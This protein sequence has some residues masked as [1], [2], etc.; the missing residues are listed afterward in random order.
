MM[1]Q[2]HYQQVNA[3][4]KQLM[5]N[6]CKSPRGLF[7]YPWLAT[8]AGKFY[9][10]RIFTWDAH[11][12]TL[13]F[14]MDGQPEMM[15]YFLLTM[16]QFQ[17]SNGFVPS[18]CSPDNGGNDAPGFHAQPYLAQNA[19]EYLNFSG[20]LETIGELFGKL[21]KYLDCWLTVYSAPFGLFRWEET[22]MSGFD[23]EITGTI[24]PT[25][26][27]LPPDL[28]SLLYLECRAMGYLARKLNLP[29]GE[30]EECACKIKDAVNDYLWDEEFGIYSSFNLCSGK[31]Q[32]SWGDGSLNSSVGKYAYI[33]CPSL[34]VL[35][36]GIADK[37]R[38]ERMIKT[39]VLSPDH[40]RSRFGIRSLSKSS[41]YCNNA[42]WGNP[43]RFGSW[44]RLTNSNWQG[45]VWVPLNWFVFHA[46]LRYGFANEAAELA[47]DTVELIYKS[48]Q[49]LGF[50]RENYHAETGEGLY[51]DDF[52]SWNLL[53]DSM[54]WYLNS[55]EKTISLFPW[56][57]ENQ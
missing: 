8:T 6:I 22:L 36:A 35:F 48:F 33:S 2:S 40:F 27:I 7:P 31:T 28:P 12:M 26:T 30:F 55:P 16:F 1:Q 34:L 41:E 24:F 29:D 43:P 44:K 53:T 32:T 47:D 25:G 51:A 19:A 4:I 50:M 45:P 5:Q 17:R 42:R 3:N 52:A 23:N 11:H 38:A 10:A 9:A 21:K 56:E 20:D 13:R 15:K 46:L 37:A 39:Y 57:N 54:H 14:A 49:E 18:I